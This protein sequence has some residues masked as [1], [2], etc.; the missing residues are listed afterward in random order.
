[1]LIPPGF[2]LSR[3]PQLEFYAGDG[4]YGDRKNFI[5]DALT[6]RSAILLSTTTTT[7]SSNNNDTNSNGNNNKQQSPFQYFCPGEN[8]NT[9][10]IISVLRKY[11]DTL[12]HIKMFFPAPGSPFDYTDI[13]ESIAMQNL[14]TLCCDIMDYSMVSIITLLN[15]CHNTIQEVQLQANDDSYILDA[16]ALQS[17]QTLPQLRTLAIKPITFA[18]ESSVVALLK[19]LPALENLI[20]KQNKP[21][22]LPKEAGPLLKNLR[23]LTLTRGYTWERDETQRE[24]RLLKDSNLFVSLAQSGSKLE[25]VK[26]K[27]CKDDGIS[28][29]I[30]DSLADFPLLKSLNVRG[31]DR[32]FNGERNEEKE[33]QH[34]LKLLNRFLYGP[35][36]SINNNITAVPSTKIENLTLSQVS[37]LTYDMLH[38]LSDFVNLQTLEVILSGGYGNDKNVSPVLPDGELLNVN[39]CGIMELLRK[40]KK[41]KRVNFQPM[42]SFG[43]HLPSYYLEEKLAEE[44]KDNFQLQKF[45]VQGPELPFYD[46]NLEVSV[47]IINIHYL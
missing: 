26:L 15:T 21:I 42:I 6:P 3:C 23:H 17:L 7:N 29:L 38:I 19:R 18:D 2:V 27:S 36:N 32:Y 20:L 31:I 13:F 40:C 45:I 37:K 16:P 24:C 28:F 22:T 10:Q 8:Y 34:M 11:K 44:Q 12:K 41:L 25:S 33:E 46:K 5:Q 4:S 1:M 35:A 47:E 30:L 9:D 39:L 43:E 14:R